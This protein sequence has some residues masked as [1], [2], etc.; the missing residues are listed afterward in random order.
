M[1]PS[2]FFARVRDA[3]ERAQQEFWRVI[4][5]SFPEAPSGDFSPEATLALEKSLMLAVLSWT[6]TNL[7]VNTKAF[8]PSKPSPVPDQ[9]L[10]A[11]E[12]EYEAFKAWLA[13][14]NTRLAE[15]MA[16]GEEGFR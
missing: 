12:W 14:D 8:A 9:R 10:S 5:E 13:N 11:E 16:L 7:P 4:A 3:V 1:N 6:R 15:L 2:V